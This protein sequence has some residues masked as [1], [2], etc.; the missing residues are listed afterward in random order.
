MREVNRRIALLCAQPEE[1]F[2]RLF[3]DGF[4]KQAFSLG[5]DVCV[6]SMYLKFQGTKVTEIGESTIFNL[7]NCKAFDG[8]VVLGDTIQTPGVLESLDERFHKEADC[9]VL[10]VDSQT[11]YHKSINLRHYSAIVK[12]MEHLINDHGYKDIAF[13][14]G[15]EWHPH[16]KERLQA[17]IDTMDRYGLPI[18]DD[19]IFYGDF[20]YQTAI[21]IADS[22][23]TE[24]KSLPEVF[25]CANDYMA[26]GLAGALVKNGV[27]VPEDVAVI[28]YDSVEEGRTSPAPITSIPLPVEQYGK[29]AAETVFGL[30]DGR[31]IQ[32][33]VPEYELFRGSSCGCHCESCV[34]KVT[35][36]PAWKTETFSRPFYSLNNRM[37][38]S[39]YAAEKL[40]GVLDVVMANTYQLGDV[41]SIRICLNAPWVEGG[42][43]KEVGTYDD[44]IYEV[45]TCVN[46]CRDS[47]ISFEKS[48]PVKDMLPALYEPHDSPRTLLFTPLFFDTKCFGYGVIDYT[49]RIMNVDLTYMFFYRYVMVGLDMLR[50]QIVFQNAR[51]TIDEFKMIDQLTGN[52]N[53]EGLVKR[54][55]GLKGDGGE[56]NLTFVAVDISGLG[57][58]NSEKGRREGDKVIIAFGKLLTSSSES[59]DRLYGRLGNDEFIIALKWSDNSDECVDSIINTLRTKLDEYNKTQEYPIDFTYGYSS[60]KVVREEDVENLINSAVSNKNGNKTKNRRSQIVSKFSEEEK[61]LA[62]RIEDILDNNKFDYHLQPI[63]ETRKGDIFA[64]E[65][66][67][68]PVTDPYIAPPVIIEYAKRMGRIEEVERYTFMNVLSII[69]NNMDVFEGKKVFINSLPGVRI[70]GKYRLQILERIRAVADKVVIE[71]TEHSEVDD[72]TL[73]NMREGYQLT[74]VQMAIDDYGTGYSNIVNLLRYMPDYVKIDR[75]LIAGIEDNPQKQHFVSEIVKFAHDNDFKVLAEGVESSSELETS[76]KLGADLV[77]GYYTARPAKDILPELPV[78]KRDEIFHYR[79]KYYSN[80]L[81]VNI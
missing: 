46:G 59:K 33:F 29:Y 34:P 18:K 52:L 43:D 77:Q 74:G 44:T 12:L 22:F 9:P 6:F 79:D 39:L 28:G 31:E 45:M 68:R 47:S 37:L 36:R 49:G 75:M 78:S 64:Y 15:K 56:A 27:R 16:S 57:F 3:I 62:N 38:E 11:K 23:F 70:D 54:S 41:E 72:D 61:K 69:E 66:L 2:Q 76:I 81:E 58:I 13:V 4:E 42:F 19:R 55:L 7:I 35:L 21:S 26:I 14:T 60:G 8:I 53:Y 32:E 17:Y 65:A 25:A 1:E 51:S 80:T 50:R 10:F 5:F 71:L 24:H 63:V 40:N 20:W 67:M 48:F 30:M 73:V